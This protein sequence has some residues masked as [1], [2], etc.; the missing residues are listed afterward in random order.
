MVSMTKEQLDALRTQIEEDYRL[1]LAAIERLQRRFVNSGPANAPAL[2]SGN[3]N[4]SAPAEP[5]APAN[6]ASYWNSAPA[7]PIQ[8]EIPPSYDP[9]PIPQGDEL[10]T[11]LRSIF[12]SQRS[13]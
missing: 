13:R 3:V 11:S 5:S 12:T 9:A 6:T 8:E 1:D 2:A 10:H 4:L 7:A